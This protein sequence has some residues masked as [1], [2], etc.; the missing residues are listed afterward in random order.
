[1]THRIY[2]KSCHEKKK[3]N[4]HL[5]VRDSYSQMCR[6]IFYKHIELGLKGLSCWPTISAKFIKPASRTKYD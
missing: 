5:N 3:T 6:D 4:S 2:H 1:M